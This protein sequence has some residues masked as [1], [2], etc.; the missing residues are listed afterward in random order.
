MVS[1][2]LLVLAVAAACGN[3]FP[4]VEGDYGVPTPH[5]R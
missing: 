5:C 3:W 1:R 2:M 4:P